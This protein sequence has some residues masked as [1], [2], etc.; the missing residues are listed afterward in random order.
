MYVS[1]RSDLGEGELGFASY[2]FGL[3]MISCVLHACTL[4]V[5][6]LGEIA[7]RESQHNALSCPATP[8]GPLL[9]ANFVTAASAL[10]PAAARFLRGLTLLMPMLG[11]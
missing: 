4:H 11:V 6:T 9:L 2:S 8:W 7:L 1:Q 10:S 5:V 3:L